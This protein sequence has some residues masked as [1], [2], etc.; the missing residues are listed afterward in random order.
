MANFGAKILSTAI[1]GVRAQQAAIA[2]AGNNIANVNTSGYCRRS[3]V[4]QT[5]YTSGSS[6]GLNV[7][8]GVQ[9]GSVQRVADSYLQKL[10]YGAAAEK[11][12]NQTQNDYLTRLEEVFNLT[13]TSNTIGSTLTAFFTS[14]DDL[15]ANPSSIELR[16][17]VIESAQTLV[18][19]ISDSFEYLAGLQTEA[20]Q[21]ISTEIETV[22]SLTQQI[23]GLNQ[24]ISVVEAAGNGAV[25]ADERDARDAL[26]EDLS[27]KISFTSVEREDGSVMISL[28]NGLTLVNGN[29][30]HD[31]EVTN[32]PSYVPAGAEM[33]KSLSGGVLSYIVYDMGSGSSSSQ[34]DVSNLLKDGGGT[35]GAYLKMRGTIDA[36]TVADPTTK[37]CFEAEGIIVDVASRVEAITKSLLTAFNKK[38]LGDDR[39]PSSTHYDPSSGDL[40]GN[41][42]DVFGLFDFDYTLAVHDHDNDGVPS[43]SDLDYFTGNSLVTNFSSIL[44]LSFTDPTRLA[45]ALDSSTGFPAAAQF[46]T[47]D[48]RNLEALSSLEDATFDLKAGKFS[49]KAT[50]GE[51]YNQTVGYVGNLKSSS[52]V[53]KSVS[54]AN[55]NTAAERRDEVSAVSLDE[56]YTSLIIFQ[57]AYQAS[58]K[59]IRIADELMQEVIQLI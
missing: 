5:S 39:D 6:G 29:S 42:P 25:A 55:Y 23:A 8:N 36:P 32:R 47:G 24:K 3:V 52:D 20:D 38:Y 35:I 46:A 22:N 15:T 34:I 56:E 10:L 50:L 7:G 44:K 59:M 16:S 58:A 17:N 27:E 13:G 37:N 54:D 33:P 53:A 57:R 49:L 40:N 2:T 31:L 30:S 41:T 48:G 14:I 26:M 9:V 45:A 18:S 21:R 28:S 43:T 11:S 19:T 1:S 4:L 12:S 51:A